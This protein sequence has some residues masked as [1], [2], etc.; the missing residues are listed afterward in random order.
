MNHTFPETPKFTFVDTDSPNFEE[1]QKVIKYWHKHKELIR[2]LQFYDL[3]NFED[4]LQPLKDKLLNNN[5]IVFHDNSLPE[6]EDKDKGEIDPK[7]GEI[8]PKQTA[9]FLKIHEIIIACQSDTLCVE[10]DFIKKIL[11]KMD[12]QKSLLDN[13]KLFVEKM[14]LQFT[15][16]NIIQLYTQ[17][18]FRHDLG[19]DTILK[20]I[21]KQ[22]KSGSGTVKIDEKGRLIR[23]E[24]GRGEDKA[25]I[26]IPQNK[27]KYCWGDSDYCWDEREFPEELINRLESNKSRK[28]FPNAIP[29]SYRLVDVNTS[30]KKKYEEEVETK[31]KKLQLQSTSKDI[32]GVPMKFSQQ[33]T[34]Q[35]E[36][37]ETNLHRILHAAKKVHNRKFIEIEEILYSFV[38]KSGFFDH[39]KEITLHYRAAEQYKNTEEED[40]EGGSGKDND[41]N[42][43]SISFIYVDS[44]NTIEKKFV[45]EL[46][47]PRSG[48][49]TVEF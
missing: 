15:D 26:I 27:N 3:L 39:I 23:M 7:Q 46:K 13:I 1:K 20:A 17:K 38:L 31:M 14:H 40:E 49:I 33:M 30:A 32:L 6:F 8:D 12:I 37:K 28:Y 9:Q 24:V 22:Q 19:D 10:P 45:I 5:S 25:K 43:D 36:I 41:T 18:D 44:G 35:Q 11:L 34:F 4:P 29:K 42:N 48:N 2:V 47:N 16:E 21:E